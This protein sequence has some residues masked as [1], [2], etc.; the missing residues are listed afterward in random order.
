VDRD[1]EIKGR[2][3]IPTRNDG[4]VVRLRITASLPAPA[5]AGRPPNQASV[6][7][8]AQT[9]ERELAALA[10]RWTAEHD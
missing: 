2:L 9:I 7:S 4:P 3:W 8:A 10:N 5:P 1:A 6:A